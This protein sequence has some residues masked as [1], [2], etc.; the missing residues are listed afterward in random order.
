MPEG[1]DGAARAF[2]TEIAP[3]STPARDGAG[4]FTPTS[5]PEPL[6]EERATEGDP[7]T[8]DTR[9]AGQDERLARIERRI[10]DG[11]AEEGDED[12]LRRG[13]QDREKLRNAPGDGRHERTEAVEAGG[14]N[15]P[16]DRS[17]GEHDQDPQGDDGDQP[18]ERGEGNADG[19]SEQD[20]ESQF[21]ITTLDGKPVE[22]FEVTVDGRPEEVS[23][24]EALAGYIKEATFKTRLNK[25]HEARQAVEAQA[26]EVAQWR[27]AYAQRLQMLDRELAELTPAEPDW[28]REF[29]TNPQQARD[30]QK[31][32]QAIYGK[33]Q[34]IAQEMA[35]VAAET[36][37]QGDRNTQRYAIQQFGEFVQEA[38]YRDEK[39]LQ[40]ELSVIRGYLR[41]EGF[42]EAEAAT[43]YDKRMLHVA[44]KAA[45][46]DQMMRSKPKPVRPGQGKAL[47]PGVASP[48][49]HAA[50]RH[51]DEAQQ[52]LAK[53]GR[54]EDAASVMA[55]LIR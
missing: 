7:L 52:K 8:G 12:R 49:G 13:V 17:P 27:D 35:N 16:R 4:R 24:D 26:S 21:K 20:A 43:V 31:A 18:G 39:A 5:R 15:D 36:R 38:N 19:A 29:A 23:L 53:T 33:R 42:S 34:Q 2:Q 50:R 11:R 28:D 45:L 55:R 54:L 48:V 6:F 1:L 41:R 3:D 10:A 46:Y 14:D 37:A 44:R 30:K 47:I 51:I 32:Y 9:D 40:S 25:V 22:K